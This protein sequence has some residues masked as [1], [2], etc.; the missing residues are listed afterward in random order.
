[1]RILALSR[2][3]GISA[4]LISYVISLSGLTAAHGWDLR[5]KPLGFRLQITQDRTTNFFPAAHPLLSSNPAGDDLSREPP[6]DYK[7]VGNAAAEITSLGA[8]GWVSVFS[9]IGFLRPTDIGTIGAIISRTDAYD[10]TTRQGQEFDLDT[11]AITLRYGHRI[12]PGL[13]LGGSVKLGRSHV[14]LE[15]RSLKINSSSVTSE[16]TLAA[17]G[18]P[19]ADWTAGI[20]LTQAPVWSSSETKTDS[21]RT[22]QKLSTVLTRLRGGLGWRP[23]PDTGTLHGR[24][25]LE[26]AQQDWL[27]RFRT[28]ISYR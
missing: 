6:F 3:G 24:R 12:K 13:A 14:S 19:A 17:M 18:T 7:A 22:K 2:S 16:F 15:D 11:D 27:S 1:M 8:G 23:V 28:R 26:C 4:A 25:V 9:T 20:F 21:E 5:N 10:S